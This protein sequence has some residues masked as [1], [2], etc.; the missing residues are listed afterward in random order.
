MHEDI[1]SKKLEESGLCLDDANTLG[2]ELITDASTLHRGFDV[3]PAIKINYYDTQSMPLSDRQGHEPYYRLRYLSKPTGFSQVKTKA[4]PKY[5]Q[6]SKTLPVA[7][8]AKSIAWQPIINDCKEPL[9][10]TE[11]E[12]KA[13]KACKEGFPTIG[14]GGVHSWRA[15]KKGVHFL[16]S[17]VVVNWIGRPVYICY[18]SDYI[19]N[20][21]VCL[22]L[23]QL[24]E[25]LEERGAEVRLVTLPQ[26]LAGTKTGLDDFLV[27]AGTDAVDMFRQLLKN[28]E[29]IGISRTLFSLN[30]KYVCIDHPVCV[31]NKQT[32]REVSPEKFKTFI[33]ADTKYAQRE[34]LR[35]GSIRYKY[36]SAS[37]RW[38]EWQLR[39]RVSELTYVPGQPFRVMRDDHGHEISGYNMWSGW[40]CNPI[41]GDISLFITLIDFLFKEAKDSDKNWF[42][43]WLAY[44][45]KY[46]GTKLHTTV[47]LHSIKQGIGKSL[48]GDTIGRL[49]GEN[50]QSINQEDLQKNFTHWAVNKQFIMGD[51]VTGTS[52]RQ[53]ADKLK[54]LITQRSMTINKKHIQE[55]TVPDCINYIFTSNQPDAFFLEDLDRRYFIHECPHT[56]LDVKFYTEDYKQWLWSSNEG[57][58]ALLYY[59]QNRDVSTFDPLAPAPVTTAKLQMIDIGRSDVGSWVRSLQEAP[60][61]LLKIGG[62]VYSCDLITSGDLLCYYDPM[63]KKRIT[64]GGIAREL[65]RAG[66]PMAARGE[67]ITTFT[68]QK[69]LY[70]LKNK[71][72]WSSASRTEASKYYKA[73]SDKLPI[74]F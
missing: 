18:D 47:V 53:Y 27:Q 69:R 17:L 71:E 41:K 8:Y 7:F 51:D 54:S 34:L 22:A 6:K 50:Y 61:A 68:G 66:F 31:Y 32:R 37:K 59:F 29:P 65:N 3:L 46:P 19:T 55:Y 21:Q 43:N 9:I 70:I 60:E 15:L 28:S 48:V 4:T 36:V 25:A 74:K 14:L 49:Y 52:Q 56:A 33:E 67:R 72:K 30:T 23:K 16:D 13:A 44:P 39:D 2:F 62:E 38:I 35:D 42:L 73:Y 12:F 5:I 45:I 64:S 63:S 58:S 26:L 11:G 57:I 24:A 40:G 10:I 1:Y 20:P